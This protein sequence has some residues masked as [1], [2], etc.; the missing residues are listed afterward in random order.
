MDIVFGVLLIGVGAI[1]LWQRRSFAKGAVWYNQW[2]ARMLPGST[3]DQ[4]SSGS[5]RRSSALG[6]RSWGCSRWCWVVSSSS[7]GPTEQG[8]G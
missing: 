2:V 5:P 7:Y 4:E 1:M 8:S 6:L 3:T